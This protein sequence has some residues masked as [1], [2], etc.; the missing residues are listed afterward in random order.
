MT[1]DSLKHA[2]VRG[3]ELYYLKIKNNKG[4]ELLINVGEKT[5]ERVKELK[6]EEEMPELPLNEGDT[7]EPKTEK[8]K[9]KK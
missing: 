9:Q 1:I 4:N 7:A 5:A 3:K 2:D 8:V 6:E